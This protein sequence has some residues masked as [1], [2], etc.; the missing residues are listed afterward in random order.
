[1]IGLF[2]GYICVGFCYVRRNTLAPWK[3]VKDEVRE[4]PTTHE[5]DTGREGLCQKRWL[6]RPMEYVLHL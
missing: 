1:M 5:A 3:S 4:G 2:P 6:S